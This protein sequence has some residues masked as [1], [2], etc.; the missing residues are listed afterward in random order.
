MIDSD[1]VRTIHQWPNSPNSQIPCRGLQLWKSSTSRDVGGGAGEVSLVSDGSVREKLV[2]EIGKA[3]ASASSPSCVGF[4][5]TFDSGWGVQ[6]FFSTRLEHVAR[7]RLE[8]EYRTSAKSSAGAEVKIDTGRQKVYAFSWAELASAVENKGEG[9]GSQSATS[10]SAPPTPSPQPPNAAPQTTTK[11][12]KK[13]PVLK[14]PVTPVK[15][16]SASANMNMIN[17]KAST[18][19]KSNSVPLLTPNESGV[20]QVQFALGFLV[21][22]LLACNVYTA[23]KTGRCGGRGTR[24]G[25]DLLSESSLGA[26]FGLTGLW[27]QHG[28]GEGEDPAAGV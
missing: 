9:T 25:R 7:A 2:A 6:S 14:L 27:G 10:T 17:N 18:N 21:A 24:A 8:P 22:I 13:E 19:T 23:L 1:V 3:K 12:A 20:R 16:S 28:G 4:V 11:D 5:A 26:R 15:S